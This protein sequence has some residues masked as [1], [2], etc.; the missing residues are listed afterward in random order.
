MAAGGGNT[1][2]FSATSTDDLLTL[3]QVPIMLIQTTGIRFMSHPRKEDWNVGRR[4]V[5]G[6]MEKEEGNK[7]ESKYDSLQTI[8]GT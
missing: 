4:L 7:E 6:L 3:S 1:I 8:Y 5:V 2:F